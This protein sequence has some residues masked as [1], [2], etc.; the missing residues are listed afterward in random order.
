MFCPTSCFSNKIQAYQFKKKFF[1][2]KRERPLLLHGLLLLHHFEHLI[3]IHS[4]SN[5]RKLSTTTTY[6]L[7]ACTICMMLTYIISDPHWKRYLSLKSSKLATL[8]VACH[9]KCVNLATA[10]KDKLGIQG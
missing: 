10:L 4:T 3:S 8:F 9:F 6:D 7:C 5:I 1:W 2:K